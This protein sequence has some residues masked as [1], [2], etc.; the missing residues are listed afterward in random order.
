M[1]VRRGQPTDKVPDENMAAM[2][3]KHLEKIRE[4]LAAQP[5][6]EVLYIKYNDILAS[7][8]ESVAKLNAFFDNALDAE[9]MQTVVDNQL[10]RQ[11]R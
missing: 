8:A 1:L 5:N 4:W 7:P 6:M 3:E 2:F 9:A 10:Y 11:R